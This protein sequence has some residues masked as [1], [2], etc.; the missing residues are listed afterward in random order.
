[1]KT[2]R[3]AAGIGI[4]AGL[5][6]LVAGCD[7]P[8]KDDG[9]STEAE[10]AE[11]IATYPQTINQSSADTVVQ[12]DIEINGN[13]NSVVI[14]IGDENAPENVNRRDQVPAEEPIETEEPSAP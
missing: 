6:L 14:V 11:A 5:A 3:T 4:I 12:P 13:N 9:E 2:S 1:M 10:D 8:F 7:S